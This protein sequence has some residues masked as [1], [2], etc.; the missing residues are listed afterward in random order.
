MLAIGFIVAAVLGGS[1]G[2]K[3]DSE[4]SA[5]AGAGDRPGRPPKARTKAA[6]RPTAEALGYPAFATNN[7]TRIGG[8]DAAANAAAVALAVFPSTTA[9][10]RPAAVALVDEEDWAGGDRRLGPDG[11]RRCGRRS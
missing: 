8:S 5:R 1:G 10:Q 11:R 3:D 7:T 9:A 6:S 2:A 4:P